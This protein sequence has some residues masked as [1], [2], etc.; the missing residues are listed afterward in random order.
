MAQFM[1]GSSNTNTVSAESEPAD[2]DDGTDGAL[3]V[4]V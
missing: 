2:D 1:L 4:D 3:R